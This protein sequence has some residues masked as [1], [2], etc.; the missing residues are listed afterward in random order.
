MDGGSVLVNPNR[1][2]Y[3]S[4]GAGAGGSIR[5]VARSIVNKGNLSAKGG[6]ASGIDPR[7]PGAVS[8]PIREG[9]VAV[10]ESRFFMTT[11]WSK[12]RWSLTVE[13]RMGMPRQGEAEPFSSELAPLPLVDLNL[14][15]GTVVFDTA[16]AGLIHPD[17]KARE[18]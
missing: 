2:A 10:V 5:L 17:S 13:P 8:F 7:E 14:T 11:P 6:H 16:G 9:P 18:P 4:G 3:F 15:S 12:V 1:G